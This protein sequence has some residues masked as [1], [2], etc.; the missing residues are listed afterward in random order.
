M[1]QWYVYVLTAEGKTV[2][3]LKEWRTNVPQTRGKTIAKLSDR[4]IDFAI[5][6]PLKRRSVLES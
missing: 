4:D 2:P 1:K 6:Y 3:F 5:A